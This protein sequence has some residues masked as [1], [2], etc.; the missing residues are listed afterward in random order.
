[1]RSGAAKDR[2]A[3]SNKEDTG[4]TYLTVAERAAR[5]DE[6]NY[7]PTVYHAR[8]H[9][10]QGPAFDDPKDYFSKSSVE[11]N[12]G[13]GHYFTSSLD[14][15]NQNYARVD[16]EGNL[17]GPDWSQKVQLAAE[18]DEWK[19]ERMRDQDPE[20]W[21]HETARLGLAEDAGPLEVSYA[22]HAMRARG[23][24]PHIVPARL[25]MDKAVYVGSPHRLIKDTFLE[26]ELPSAVV[27]QAPDGKYIVRDKD[28]DV[29]ERFDDE[30]EAQDY[31]NEH[32][33]YDEPEGVGAEIV[34]YV[35]NHHPDE[36]ELIDSLRNYMVDY[37]GARAST[38]DEMFAKQYIEHPET[39]E[40]INKDVFTNALRAAGYDLAVYPEAN[41][42][43]SGM[44]MEPGTTHYVKLDNKG[45][46]SPLAR[47][48][49][50]KR[51][52]P[53]MFTANPQAAALISA[54]QA[55]SFGNSAPVTYP[56]Q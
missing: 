8:H 30:A 2:F 25:N 10:L 21:R 20:S 40:I 44:S 28:G 33:A 53:N 27:E 4:A 1:L 5:G 13:R 51:D 35:V 12:A 22:V 47:F 50:N 54:L 15:A 23:D 41:A 38:L 26:Y 49:P 29:V 46:K 52:D 9:D 55:P 6:Q 31:A 11:G 45:I 17:T 3:F 7:S 43:F 16:R 24:G 32:H 39:G 37:G 14:D 18:R 42:R 34:R 36:H 56:A 19:Y 48:D